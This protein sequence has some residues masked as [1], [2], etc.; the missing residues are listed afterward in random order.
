MVVS[1][2]RTAPK[3]W[4]SGKRR[5]VVNMRYVN[6]FIPE[7]AS[8]CT[9]DTL[10][11][12][13]NL[14][15]TGNADGEG[16]WGLTMD[17]A[18]GYHNFGIVPHQLDLMGIAV[19]TSELPPDAIAELRREHPHCEDELA[20][21]FYFRMLAL[22]FGLAPSCVVFSDII[23][24]LAASWRRHKVCGWPVRLTSYIDDC[25]GAI[26]SLRAALV[27][28]VELSYEVYAAG[29]TLNEK[30]RLCPARAFTFLG[31][32]VDTVKGVFR[33]PEK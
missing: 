2:V 4:R 15:T 16:M 17:L 22:P 14:F 27:M 6:S 8:A 1:P 28:V 31:L 25:A 18:S 33:L 32:V 7:E 29:L 12:V 20:G 5:F 11:K 24:A 23:T 19:H 3:G 9:L 30:C 13:R 26:E 21:L 10:A